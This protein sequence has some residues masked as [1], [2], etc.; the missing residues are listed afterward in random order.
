MAIPGSELYAKPS[1]SPTSYLLSPQQKQSLDLNYTV[2]LRTNLSNVH[3]PPFGTTPVSP[4]ECRQNS[5]H[6]TDGSGSVHPVSSQFRPPMRPLGHSIHS[7]DAFNTEAD[8]QLSTPVGFTGVDTAQ[9]ST[10]SIANAVARGLSALDPMSAAQY[11]L[12]GDDPNI[13]LT[14]GFTYPIFGGDEYT[15]SPVARE[16]AF[17]PWLFNEN[18][19]TISDMTPAS[20]IMPGYVDIAATQIQGPFCADD[21]FG[22]YYPP[23]VQP[24]DPMSVMSILESTTPT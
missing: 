15:R 12:T 4:T 21:H 16:A 2:D 20:G 18:Q 9:T 24:Q 17:F 14:A 1:S 5:F 11:A 6:S 23:N 3:E 7:T 22:S 19:S 13:D 8:P 10:T